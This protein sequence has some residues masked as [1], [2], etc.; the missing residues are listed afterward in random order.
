MIDSYKDGV[1]LAKRQTYESVEP[2]ID[3]HEYGH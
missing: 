1:V 3:L 2:R